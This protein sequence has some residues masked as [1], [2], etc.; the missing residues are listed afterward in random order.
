MSLDARDCTEDELRDF[1]RE[2]YR[3][4]VEGL[5]R[6]SYRT[7][8]SAC[9]AL[10]RPW[11]L[12]SQPVQAAPDIEHWAA[13]L[14]KLRAGDPRE[15]NT[16]P[17]K[18]LAGDRFEVGKYRWDYA[19]TTT[20]A[21]PLTETP[22]DDVEELDTATT[23]ARVCSGYYPTIGTG[24]DLRAIREMFR[25]GIERAVSDAL[26]A[27]RSIYERDYG[28]ALLGPVDR[29]RLERV[30]DFAAPHF[31]DEGALPG[32][33]PAPTVE[34]PSAPAQQELGL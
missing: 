24:A 25:R 32:V 20:P 11:R 29:A 27:I 30:L 9:R 19:W 28:P 33:S 4:G 13:E 26:D 31:V 34:R 7:F 6:E 2:V 10:R 22:P 18:R 17:V 15:L 21:W 16:V 23:L 14:A 12:K 3:L 8:E 1:V 5:D